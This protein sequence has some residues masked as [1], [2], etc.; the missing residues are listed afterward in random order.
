LFVFVCLFFLGGG[1]LFKTLVD[2]KNHGHI[3]SC[4]LRLHKESSVVKVHGS[5]IYPPFLYPI[6]FHSIL[7]KFRSFHNT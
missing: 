5:L 2:R 4:G 7:C 1:H 3:V 6:L